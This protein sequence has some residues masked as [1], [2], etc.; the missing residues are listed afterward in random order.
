M[1]VASVVGL[2]MPALD[3][4]SVGTVGAGLVPGVAFLLV[5]RRLL[6]AR[7]IHVDGARRASASMLVFAVLLL[8]SLPEGFAIGTAY[9]SERRGSACS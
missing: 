1:A 8:H 5:S 9:A 4:G 3:E 7:D 2:L 6:A